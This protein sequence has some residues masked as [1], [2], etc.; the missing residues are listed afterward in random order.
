MRALFLTGLVLVLAVAPLT[1]QQ[2]DDLSGLLDSLVTLWERNDASRLV[3][4]GADVGLELDVY[5]TPMGPLAGRRAA[6]A[7]RHL[8]QAQETVAVRPTSV[9]RVAGT[10]DRAF[11]EL[12]WE[13]RQAG[14]LMTE[15]ATVFMGLVREA[16]GWRVSQIRILP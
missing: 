9:S 13:V 8:F 3:G 10:D 11:V 2:T 12:T 14:G 7:L 4:L 5:G 1:A 6:A 16:R 15:S